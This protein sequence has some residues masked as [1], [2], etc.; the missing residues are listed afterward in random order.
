[1]N[2]DPMSIHARAIFL[3]L[4]CL[5]SAMWHFSFALAPLGGAPSIVYSL[6]LSNKWTFYCLL[7]EMICLYLVFLL[8]C[9]WQHL[10]DFSPVL[11]HFYAQIL[12]RYLLP[13]RGLKNIKLHKQVDSFIP[14][15]VETSETYQLS[16]WWIYFCGLSI[17]PSS[18]GSSVHALALRLYWRSSVFQDSG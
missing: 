7:L 3:L 15:G 14:W 11:C 9:W 6:S 5:A 8:P 13:K 2:R 17:H 1:M 10:M 4:F 12:W 16:P 18:F